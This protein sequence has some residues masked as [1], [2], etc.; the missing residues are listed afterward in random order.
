[1]DKRMRMV[2][3]AALA[4]GILVSISTWAASPDT[5]QDKPSAQA[6]KENAANIGEVI[7]TMSGVGRKDKETVIRYRK[8][9]LSV[10]SVTVNGLDIPPD[11]L[12][13][14]KDDLMKALEYPRL[15]EL[16]DRMEAVEKS[17]RSMRPMNGDKGRA[18]DE[19][20]KELD[21]FLARVSPDNK[22]V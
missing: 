16:L 15:R 4:A 17:I 3:T 6:E 13:R 2:S 19:L 22:N 5:V 20:L 10:L 1:M 7:I 8:S 21:G 11:R 18:L 9:D 14:F 12:G